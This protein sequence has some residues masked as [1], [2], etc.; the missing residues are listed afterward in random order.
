MDTGTWQAT[1]CGVA[2]SQTASEVPSIPN[3][4]GFLDSS[5]ICDPEVFPTPIH[6]LTQGYIWV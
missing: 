6:G 5:S 1:V 2:K 3:I 4:L